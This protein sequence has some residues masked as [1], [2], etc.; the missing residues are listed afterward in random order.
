MFKK[1]S[2]AAVFGAMALLATG[3]TMAE[4]PTAELRVIGTLEVPSC[5]V[6]VDDDGIYDFGNISPTIIKAGTATTALDPIP[7]T[8]TVNCSGPTV[9]TF[10]A[11]DNRAASS[12]GTNTKQFGLGNVNENGKIG[13]YTVNMSNAE[14]GDAEATMEPARVFASNTSGISN[15]AA[16]DLDGG[17]N[18]KMGWTNASNTLQQGQIFRADL[19]VTPTLAGTTTMG[20][21]ITD[22]VDLDGSLTLTFSFGLR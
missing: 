21:P 20:G 22:H 8:W 15:A 2:L 3:T 4:A 19:I 18:Y 14:V 5:V 11:S 16:V 10:E 12:S 13:Y 1:T 17:A 7:K 9:L 6:D